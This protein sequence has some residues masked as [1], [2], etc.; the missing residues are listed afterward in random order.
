MK[1]I[2]LTA[3]AVLALASCSKPVAEQAPAP[4]AEA[5]PEPI[6]V[7]TPAP[8]APPPPPVTMATPAPA[9]PASELAPPGVFYL[10][11]AA[12][13]ETPDGIRGLP[14][15]TGV[16]LVRAGVYLT[17]Y[18]EMPLDPRQLTNDMA[19]A[20]RARDAERATQATVQAQGAADAARAAEKARAAAVKAEAEQ[21]TAMKAADRQRV[22][23]RVVA[24]MKQEA[25]LEVQ[26]NNL[27]AK[28]SN[29]SFNKEVKGRTVGST[30][31]TQLTTARAQLEIIRAQ[32][33]EANRDLRK[34]R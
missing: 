18:G 20:R 21:A 10:L 31:N 16:K 32:L 6:A 33:Q 1:R 7:A 23:G 12:R 34:S 29:E 9:I 25:A 19:A 3:L 24:L 26:I 13:V 28:A 22:E 30:T 27:S 11:A 14:P 2:G 8:A 17:P 15:G 4:S 5:T